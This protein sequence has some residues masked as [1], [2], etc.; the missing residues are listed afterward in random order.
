M[1]AYIGR[2][3]TVQTVLARLVS[4]GVVVSVVIFPRAANESA[5]FTSQGLDY[6]AAHYAGAPTAML[7]V[8]LGYGGEAGNSG[9]LTED[10]LGC[11]SPKDADLANLCEVTQLT[12]SPPSRY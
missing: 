8:W 10:Q 5:R 11:P 12:A 6:Q 4:F 7:P 2:T 1:S 3:R 9:A